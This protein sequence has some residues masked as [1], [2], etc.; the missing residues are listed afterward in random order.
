MFDLADSARLDRLIKKIQF[1]FELAMSTS[2]VSPK[3]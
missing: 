2:A 3:N 1:V